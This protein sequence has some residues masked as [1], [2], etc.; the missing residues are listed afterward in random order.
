MFTVL[1]RALYNLH[2]IALLFF[3]AKRE[4]G[5]NAY[6]LVAWQ[7]KSVLASG[8]RSAAG[9]TLKDIFVGD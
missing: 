9:R 4:S 6:K 7:G 3:L 1:K 2:A 5:I 8:N